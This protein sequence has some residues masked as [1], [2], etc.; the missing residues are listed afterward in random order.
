M[1]AKEC[2]KNLTSEDLVYLRHKYKD[3]LTTEKFYSKD[4][5]LNENVD[6][7]LKRI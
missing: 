5:E 7:V 1:I 6:K 2:L 3:I 4:K